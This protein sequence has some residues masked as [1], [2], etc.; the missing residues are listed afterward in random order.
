MALATGILVR[1]NAGLARHVMAKVVG[2]VTAD[3]FHAEGPRCWRAS[4]VRRSITTVVEEE[5]GR[6]K[7]KKK[8]RRRRRRRRRSRSRRSRTVD[9]KGV[10]WTGWGMDPGRSGRAAQGYHSCPAA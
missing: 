10:V 9:D 7:K 2:R 5:E 3:I 1:G 4:W 8:K 6:N